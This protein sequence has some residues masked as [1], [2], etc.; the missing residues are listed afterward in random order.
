MPI[1]QKSI[2]GIMWLRL[3]ISTVIGAIGGS[4]IMAVLTT[5]ANYWFAFK[6][7]AR[8]P[9]E[10]VP[11]LSLAVAVVSFALL[12]IPVIFAGITSG[13]LYLL[14][15]VLAKPK[16]DRE[17]SGDTS[18][19]NVGGMLIP[20]IFLVPL[21]LFV[22]LTG[23]VIGD[24]LSAEATRLAPEV[25]QPEP[26]TGPLA[27]NINI[28]L[29]SAFIIAALGIIVIFLRRRPLLLP[30]VIIALYVG[31]A[32]GFGCYI[33]Y[34][35]RSYDTFLRWSRFGGGLETKIYRNS[36]DKDKNPTVAFLILYTEK[37]VI[38][39]NAD[40][41]SYLEIPAD[42]VQSIEYSQ[43]PKWKLPEVKLGEQLRY[44]K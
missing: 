16:T 9:V 2:E 21:L 34:F 10:G 6:H 42:D 14:L 12:I 35:S 44:V 18:Q 38:L 26:S 17:L 7:G 8:I 13:L 15:G 11:F 31:G 30:L 5:Y 25:V 32:F 20:Y 28:L 4:S 23:V 24:R 33:L 1:T 27:I 36:G 19:P 22:L 37:R 39:Y 40:T 43:Y 3:V 41:T 29:L